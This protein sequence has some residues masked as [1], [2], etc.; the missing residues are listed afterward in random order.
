MKIDT[1]AQLE[2][3]VGE[4][5]ERA[6]QACSQCG[7]TTEGEPITVRSTIIDAL[8]APYPGEPAEG[9]EKFIRY[10]VAKRIIEEDEAGLTLEEAAM[11]KRLVGSAYGPLIVGQLWPLLDPEDVP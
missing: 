3:L 9:T 1:T 4:P 11:V 10:L 2:S 7:A 6:K 5:L 8:M